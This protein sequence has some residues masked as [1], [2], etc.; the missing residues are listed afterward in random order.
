VLPAS[1]QARIQA[2]LA[3]ESES[4]LVV[5]R[6][7]LTK[8]YREAT[9]DYAPNGFKSSSEALAYMAARLPATFAAVEDALA[10][11]PVSSIDSVLD[12]GAGPGTGTLAAALR[13]P[14][15]EHFQLVEADAF[16][17]RLSHRLLTKDPRLPVPEIDR[18]IIKIDQA[19]LLSFR[20]AQSYDLVILSYVLNEL[21]PAQQDY[22]LKKAWDASSKALVIVVPGTPVGYQHL[23]RARDLLI[24]AGCFI[25]APC[26][27]HQP[28]PLAPGDWCHFPVRFTRPNFHRDIKKV[29]LSYED[30]KFSYLVGVREP[31]HRAPARIIR[32]P[33]MRSGHVILDLCTQEGVKRQT[34]SRRDKDLYKGATDAV[35]GQEWEG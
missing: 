15:C 7:Q 11:V 32:K 35:W 33:L 34:I 4:S 14:E 9:L 20:A 31:L 30:E 21:T 10:R 22:I 23:M 8:R 25:A 5:A 29:S 24:E 3:C 12:L 16:M 17:S 27:H 6:H 13:W 2:L 18:R 28:C 19:N 1:F 26:P